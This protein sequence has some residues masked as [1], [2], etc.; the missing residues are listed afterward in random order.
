MSRAGARPQ[1]P[2][3]RLSGSCSCPW[4]DCSPVRV[5]AVCKAPAGS[6]SAGSCSWKGRILR[7]PTQGHQW[8][9]GFQSRTNHRFS[10]WVKDRLLSV[11]CS[12]VSRKIAHRSNH[13]IALLY[14]A[15]KL[16]RRK[17]GHRALLRTRTP[18]PTP[19]SA[20]QGGR[21]PSARCVLTL[22]SPVASN[23]RVCWQMK[24]R[25]V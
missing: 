16:Q 21:C 13:S 5:S 3:S 9:L 25:G 20:V 2:G 12:A 1:L 19:S 6:P 4:G 14:K 24:H 17:P 8:A 18:P 22:C 10:Y 11:A 7:S 15:Q 23:T